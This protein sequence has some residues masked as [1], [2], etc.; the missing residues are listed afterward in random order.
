MG[1]SYLR[2]K[3]LIIKKYLI[4]FIKKER[5]FFVIYTENKFNGYYTQGWRLDKNH[6]RKVC[7]RHYKR[8]VLTRTLRIASQTSKSSAEHA[9]NNNDKCNRDRAVLLRGTN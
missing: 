2:H 3:L 9:L 5:L 6:E 1:L 7:H 4:I 8:N